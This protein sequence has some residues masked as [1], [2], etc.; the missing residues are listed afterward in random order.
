MANT[1]EL[2]A[3][4]IASGGSVSSIDF[5]S[6]PG[7]YKDLCV[8]LSSRDTY[9]GPALEV[10]L[11]FNGITTNTYTYRRLQGSASSATSQ[12]GGDTKMFIGGHPGATATSNTFSSIQI[13]IPNYAGSTQK[14]VSVDA[15]FLEISSGYAFAYFNTGLNTTTSAITSITL[16]PQTQFAQHTTAY[17]YGVKNA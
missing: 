9:S 1:F 3:S 10:F 7:T 12:A 13:Y 16:L 11:R 2:I 8:I 15:A 6:I 14:S 5:T 4:S 17:L